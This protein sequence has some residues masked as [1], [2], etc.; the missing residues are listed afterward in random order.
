[1]RFVV[2]LAWLLAIPAMA[3][4]PRVVTDFGP[5]QSLVADVMGDLGSPVPS[6]QLGGG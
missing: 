4:V 3:D 6:P 5:V 1:M 2:L